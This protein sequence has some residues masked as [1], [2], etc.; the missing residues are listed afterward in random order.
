[1]MKLNKSIE[2]TAKK[3][4]LDPSKKFQ[5]I[6]HLDYQIKQNARIMNKYKT[7]GNLPELD[8]DLNNKSLN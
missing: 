1:M 4:N 7:N 8:D 5:S 3:T 2:T 6:Y